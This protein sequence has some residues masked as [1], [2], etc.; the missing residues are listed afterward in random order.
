MFFLIDQFQHVHDLRDVVRPSSY[1]L[2]TAILF[3]T[4][5]SSQNYNIIHIASDLRSLGAMF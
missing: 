2:K 4:K 3:I 5:T 1:F